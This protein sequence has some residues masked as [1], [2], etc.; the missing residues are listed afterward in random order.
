MAT[1]LSLR[2]L[3]IC[4]IQGM[5]LGTKYLA[6]LLSAGLQSAEHKVTFRGFFHWDNPLS[7]IYQ[8]FV[9]YIYDALNEQQRAYLKSEKTPLRPVPLRRVFSLC[10]ASFNIWRLYGRIYRIPINAAVIPTIAVLWQTL[11]GMIRRCLWKRRKK[12][13]R[14]GRPPSLSLLTQIKWSGFAISR[15]SQ[16]HSTI[17]KPTE[18]IF[19]V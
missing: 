3:S 8:S 13:F 12:Q 6:F 18:S 15:A 2:H 7:A 4:S 1:R 16:S 14:S 9:G 11:R 19:W 17:V 10:K 5:I